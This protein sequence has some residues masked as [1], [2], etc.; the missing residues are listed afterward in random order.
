MEQYRVRSIRLDLDLPVRFFSA[1]GLAI[2]RCLNVSATGMLA[3]F[4]KPVAVWMTGELSILL[5]DGYINIGVRVARVLDREAGL[6]F[7][8]EDDNDRFAIDRLMEF[9]SRHGRPVV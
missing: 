4:E 5:E 8:V 6:A 2:G 9:A 7:Y 1:D 3:K